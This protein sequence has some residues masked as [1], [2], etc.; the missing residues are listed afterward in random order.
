MFEQIG[1]ARLEFSSREEWEAGRRRFI[2][3]S[4]AAVL[5]GVG[6]MATS[7]FRLWAEKV[8]GVKTE[9]DKA[10]LRRF[11]M[12]HAAE[13]IIAEWFS[14][15]TGLPVHAA[16]AGKNIVHLHSAHPFIGA[17]LDRVSE[18][19]DVGLVPLELKWV[20][21]RAAREWD[22]GETPLKFIVQ[23]QHQMLATGAQGCFLAAML[24]TDKLEW[25]YIERDN[26]FLAAHLDVCIQFWKAVEAG[27]YD[28]SID[29]SEGTTEAIKRL[30]PKSDPSKIIDLGLEG[31]DLAADL[32]VLKEQAKTLE[33]QIDEKKNRLKLMLGEA[34]E[35]HTTDGR[36]ITW[37]EQ[38]GGGY[39]VEPWTTRVLRVGSVSKKKGQKK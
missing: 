13:P 33:N 12:G 37:K 1:G 27:E 3:A 17:T 21:A 15:E 23:C 10:T 4:E 7:R 18:R 38:N 6:Y 28:G 9:F 34:I 26:E 19:K 31:S 11:A 16:P 24:D 5:H 32:D 20:G 35:G 30:Y 25:R 14:Q 22:D 36:K 8:K 39:Y 29:G 2:G